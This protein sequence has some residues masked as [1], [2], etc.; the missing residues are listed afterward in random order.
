VSPKKLGGTIRTLREA[1]G[2]TQEELAA[3]VK[4]TRPYVTMLETGA[5]KN[6]SLV[7]LKRLAKALNVPVTD[8]VG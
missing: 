6:P 1:Q 7:I 5:K 3:R 2:M 8:L 4:V